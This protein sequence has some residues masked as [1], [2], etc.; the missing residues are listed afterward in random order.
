MSDRIAVMHGGT[1]AG[2]L[3]RAEATQEAILEL[4]L[5]HGLRRRERKAR[6]LHDRPLSARAVGG[7]GVRRCCSWSWRWRPRGSFGP[8]SSRRLVV[9]N[10]SVLVAAVGMTLVILCRQIDI[11]IGSHFSI[12]GVVAGL[13]ARAGLADAAGRRWGRS[14]PVAAWAPSTAPWSPGWACRRSW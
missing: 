5:G 13:L 14:R 11:S 3:D 8:N 6:W 12:C 7:R 2:A 1:V 10:A 9:S 4:A